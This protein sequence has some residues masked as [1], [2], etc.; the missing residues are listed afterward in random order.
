M[1]ETVPYPISGG[2]IM[3]GSVTGTD[4]RQNSEEAYD[5]SVSKVA[6]TLA[7]FEQ[8]NPIY[9]FFPLFIG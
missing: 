7:Q 8:E 5:A 9:Y 2:I 4:M 1:S 6:E 3:S